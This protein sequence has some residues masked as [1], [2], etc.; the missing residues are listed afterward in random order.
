MSDIEKLIKKYCSSGVPKKK[1]GEV[2]D[3]VV[4][5]AFKAGL[6][7]K[8]GL[9]VVKTTNI[10][11]GLIDENN[12]VYFDPDD[13]KKTNLDNYIIYPE[14]IVL[15]MSGTIKV[16]INKSNKN[17]YLNQRVCKFV[18]HQELNSRYLYYTLCN[19]VPKLVDV[20]SGSAVKNLSNDGIKELLISV[21]PLEVQNE[22]VKYLDKFN[23]RIELVKNKIELTSNQME[24]IKFHF[25]K[26]IEDAEI[27][28][29]SE[30]C[31]TEKGKTPIQKAIPGEYPMVVTTAERKSCN[32]YQLEEPTV[33]V[34]L[35]SSRG[36][37]VASLNQVFY[38]EGKFALGNILCAVTPKNHEYLSAKYLYYYLNF[39]KD[40]KIVSL[41]KGGANVSLTMDALKTVTIEIPPLKRQ[42]E[43]INKLEKCDRDEELLK[44]KLRL[45]YVQY[46]YYR[47]ELLSFKEV[48]VNE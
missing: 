40:T 19:S 21:P 16:G 6:F 42:N 27:K 31:K 32:T 45:L 10:Q 33:C 12:M 20:T 13:Y 39:F 44:N 30:C 43:I 29:I 38:Q 41:M 7:K 22:I 4:G 11:D 15:G 18:P 26:N 23:K 3:I 48:E 24:W 17:Y 34:P 36:H 5:F 9:P 35:V 47:D 37:G 25:L 28:S 2:C 14:D 46:E 8:E 1:L